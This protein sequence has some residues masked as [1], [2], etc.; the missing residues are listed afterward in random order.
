MDSIFG[1]P[2]KNILEKWRRMKAYINSIPNSHFP[3]PDDQP[4]LLPF[5]WPIPEGMEAVTRDGREVEQLVRFDMK[6]V[7]PI[8][9]VINNNVFRWSNKGYFICQENQDKRDLFLRRK[10]K[11]VWVVDYNNGKYEVFENRPTEGVFGST[12]YEV[13]LKPVV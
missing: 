11:K 3:L 13:T 9:G 12:H 2:D 6:N 10:E 4:D 1:I 7:Y 8:F 5:Q